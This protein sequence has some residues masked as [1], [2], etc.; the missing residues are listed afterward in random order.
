MVDNVQIIYVFIDFLVVF[1]S[2]VK[3]GRL[4]LL[5]IAR[6]SIISPFNSIEFCSVDSETY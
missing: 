2:V 6:W 3:R 1:L 4:K 5:T